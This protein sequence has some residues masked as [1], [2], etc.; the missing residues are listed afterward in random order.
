VTSE[1][2]DSAGHALVIGASSTI[3]RTIAVDLARL[4]YAVSLWGQDRQR[5]DE[6]A[7]ACAEEGPPPAVDVVD[8]TQH[9]RLPDSVRAVTARGPL[10]VVV[11]AP[12]LFDWALADEAD[13][14]VWARLFDV[15]LVAAAVLTPLVLPALIAAAPSALVYL[16]SGAAHTI[17]R[18]NAAYVASKHGLA[19][20]ARATWLDVQDRDVKVSLVSPGMVAAGGGLWS[21]AGQN[22]PHELL[23]PEDVAA[24]VRFVVTFPARGCPTE[25]RLQPQRRA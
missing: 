3:G 2:S 19:A 4:G 6:A 14:Q 8:V 10:K 17:Y 13:P 5:L 15:N 24:A 25:I 22:R 16:G 7:A 18:N 11:W 1:T 23:Q 12:G 9:D 21:P 20:L